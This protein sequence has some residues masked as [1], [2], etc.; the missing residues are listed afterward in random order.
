M[1][2][3]RSYW[4][5]RLNVEAQGEHL[6]SQLSW[7]ASCLTISHMSL[8]CLPSEGMLLFL[9][10]LFVVGRAVRWERWESTELERWESGEGS[11]LE[12]WKRCVRV[13]RWQGGK[14]G[15]I[16]RYRSGRFLV[17]FKGGG[18]RVAPRFHLFVSDVDQWNEG[19]GW[20]QDYLVWLER[21]KD[22]S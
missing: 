9:S 18:H 15:R 21:W 12:R 22:S 19:A 17:I 4:L 6:T 8:P 16:V 11:E 13:V 20:V 10:D 1:G 3:E 5:L 14:S 2:E 7:I